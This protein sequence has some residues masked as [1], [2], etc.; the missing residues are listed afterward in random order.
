MEQTIFED[1]KIVRLT[2]DKQKVNQ[3]MG[4]KGQDS[5]T[6]NEIDNTIKKDESLPATGISVGVI[7]TIV[8][9]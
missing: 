6:N 7:V 8:A 2:I 9:I 1:A 4:E 3:A 5:N